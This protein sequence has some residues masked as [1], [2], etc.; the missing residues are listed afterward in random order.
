MRGTEEGWLFYVSSFHFWPVHNITVIPGPHDSGSGFRRRNRR[1]IPPGTGECNFRA[2]GGGV[3]VGRGGD[4]CLNISTSAAR[5]GRITKKRAISARRSFA[6]GKKRLPVI[7][8]CR[9]FLFLFL[10][11]FLFFV[12]TA[13]VRTTIPNPYDAH[14]SRVLRERPIRPASKFEPKNQSCAGFVCLSGVIIKK[15]SSSF[16]I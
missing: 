8:V 7:S 15:P 6:G 13:R 1:T 10:L 16:V 5:A 11:C 9:R 2:Y 12:K 14:V 4:K 3:A